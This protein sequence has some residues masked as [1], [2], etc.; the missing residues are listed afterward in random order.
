MEEL[1]SELTIITPG[2]KFVSAADM[3]DNNENRRKVVDLARG[4]HTL[5]C[6]A[7]FATADRDKAKATQH[8]TTVAATEIAKAAGF[9][10]LVPFHFSKRY[11]LTPHLLYQEI[12]AAAGRVRVIG[13]DHSTR[14]Q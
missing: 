9:R 8:L 12:S 2:K 1:K 11:E 3:D 13:T 14:C 5:F 6:E 10:H 4:A 7:A